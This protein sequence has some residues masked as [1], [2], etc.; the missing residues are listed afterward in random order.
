MSKIQP[1]DFDEDCTVAAFEDE[2]KLI[3]RS[4]D[5]HNVRL[6]ND[7]DT[8]QIR[9]LPAE[10]GPRKIFF[11]RVAQHWIN[12]KPYVCSKV[13]A[14]DF[15]GIPDFDCPLCTLAES[16]NNSTNRDVSSVGYRSAANPQW[17]T[18]CLV[19]SKSS[20]KKDE[21]FPDGDEQWTP[22]KFFLNKQHFDEVREYYMRALQKRPAQKKSILDP[23]SGVDFF[24]RKKDKKLVLQ[25]DEARSIFPENSTP[26]DEARILD[27]IFEQIKVPH[28]EPLT[29]EEMNAALNKLEEAGF[30]AKTA[31]SSGGRRQASVVDDDDN[32]DDIRGPRRSQPQERESAPQVSRPSF[33]RPESARSVPAAKPQHTQA[34]IPSARPQARTRSADSSEQPSPAARLS[35]ASQNQ[36]RARTAAPPAP[37][38]PAT[39]SVDDD[40]D[41]TH[42]AHD[43][44]PQ[45]RDLSGVEDDHH[46]DLEAAHVVDT[47][48]PPPT[49]VE[50]VQ[51]PATKAAGSK[52]SERL[53]S[54]ITRVSQ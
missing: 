39:S 42:E 16:L 47:E 11:A 40:D 54:A 30:R 6:E 36:A 22:Y 48:E 52:M 17:L 45:S 7:G 4:S 27:R 37:V 13:T 1:S 23:Y 41:V 44:A 35:Q 34:A 33:S 18:Y 43:H 15:G 14:P 50:R 21:W 29:E 38:T 46:E 32:L 25:K 24:V 49:P 53:R 9:F 20:A 19:W 26:E 28:Y 8:W 2:V 5:D 3:K 12:K 10:M 51:Q 31:N